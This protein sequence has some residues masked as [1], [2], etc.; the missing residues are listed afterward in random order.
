[1]ATSSV[2]FGFKVPLYFAGSTSVRGEMT[3]S[4][5][6]SQS[7][8]DAISSSKEEAFPWSQESW[9]ADLSCLPC[10]KRGLDVS[11]KVMSVHKIKQR[12]SAIR[13]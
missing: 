3:L 12:K 2:M 5:L 7:T 4:D 1:M 6:I 11:Q 13:Y 10:N 8:W 9:L